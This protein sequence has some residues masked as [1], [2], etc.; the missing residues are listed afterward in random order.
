[1]CLGTTFGRFRTN[2]VTHSVSRMHCQVGSLI[3]FRNHADVPV[4][5]PPQDIGARCTAVRTD[6]VKPCRLERHMARTF[7]SSATRPDLSSGQ[8]TSNSPDLSVSTCR[9]LLQNRDR[10]PALSQNPFFP[11]MFGC[12]SRFCQAFEVAHVVIR[13]MMTPV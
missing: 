11:T 9:R 5:E 1:M 7:Q 6:S 4:S 3:A 2:S 10:H 13:C 8:K 12:Q